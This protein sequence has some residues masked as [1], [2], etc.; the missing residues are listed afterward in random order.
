MCRYPSLNQYSRQYSTSV[1]L[2]FTVEAKAMMI[3]HP[4]CYRNFTA[5]TIPSNMGQQLQLV[6]V[7]Q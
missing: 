7:E 5:R 2:S 4:L 1:V 6:P 3:S